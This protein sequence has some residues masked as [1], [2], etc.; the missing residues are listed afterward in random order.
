MEIGPL[1]GQGRTAEV[2]ACGSDRVLKLYQSWMP[3]SPIEREFAFMKTAAA[4]GLPVPAANE[5]L[6][7][8]GRLG[9]VMERLDGPS[10][11][12]VLSSQ[13]WK[14][15]SLTRQLAD[16]H[17]QMHTCL[18]P[19]EPY[20]QRQQIQDGIE[21]TQALPPEQKGPMLARL[22]ALPE[23]STLCHGDFHPDNVILTSHGPVIIDWLTGMRGHPLGDAARTS[24]LFTSGGLPP[25]VSTSTRLLINASRLWLHSIYMKRYLQLTRT[26]RADIEAWRLPLLAARLA[27]VESFPQERD[28]I[29]KEIDFLQENEKR[30]YVE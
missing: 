9:I 29:L 11:L 28:L 18:I 17:A 7:Q 3:A 8:D 1:I 13:P 20:T 27:E 22:Q 6:E 12:K 30:Q 19:Q 2:F 4:A 24:L 25:N 23:G 26:S 15:A 14:A 21:R 10:M 16:L 5:L